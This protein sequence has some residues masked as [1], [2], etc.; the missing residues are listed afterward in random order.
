MK[1][2]VSK[3]CCNFSR[4]LF[5][6]FLGIHEFV[7]LQNISPRSWLSKQT[8]QDKKYRPYVHFV[9][10]FAYIVWTTSSIH[11]YPT[12][13]VLSADGFLPVRASGKIPS[14]QNTREML[15]HQLHQ[16]YSLNIGTQ[17]ASHC[18]PLLMLLLSSTLLCTHPTSTTL[19]PILR[20]QSVLVFKNHISTKS[21][22]FFGQILHPQCLPKL[23]K[24]AKKWTSSLRD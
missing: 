24:W 3:L 23:Q 19:F 8:S 4:A 15:K 13:A 5:I 9:R 6:C 10:L 12:D 18:G 7:H 14:A 11:F 21:L 16:C 22:R 1:D 20:K 17:F 2:L